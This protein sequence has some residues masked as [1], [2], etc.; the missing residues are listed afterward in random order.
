VLINGRG[1]S[2]NYFKSEE[3]VVEARAAQEWPKNEK[4]EA[5]LL[6]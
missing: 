6:G 1:Y 4:R 5:P 2:T 3:R